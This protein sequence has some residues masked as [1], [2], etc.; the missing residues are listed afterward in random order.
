MKT[1]AAE[2]KEAVYFAERYRVVNTLGSGGM[3]TVYLAMDERLDRLIAVKVIHTHLHGN[4]SL[5]ERFKI[6]ARTVAA[7]HSPYIVEI[8]DYGTQDGNLFFI[9]EFIDGRTLNWILDRLNAEPMDPAVAAAILCQIAEGIAVAANSGI[10]HRDLKPDNILI[11][12]QGYLKV[13]DFGIAH[14]KDDARLTSTGQVLGTPKFMSPEQ[15]AGKK[16]VSLQSDMFSLGVIFYYC[17]TGHPPFQAESIPGIMMAITDTAHRPLR[18]VLP[19]IDPVLETLV[20]TLLQKDSKKRGSGATWLQQEL[21]QYLFGKAIVDPVKRIRD[22]ITELSERGIQTARE[23][24][25][26]EV[27]EAM[28]ALEQAKRT[29]V[30]LGRYSSIRGQVTRLLD[31]KSKW[32]WGIVL[33]LFVLAGVLASYVFSSLQAKSDRR[34]ASQVPGKTFPVLAKNRTPAVKVEQKT[35]A[36]P[37]VTVVPQTPPSFTPPL[38]EVPKPLVN[39]DRTNPPRIRER[40]RSQSEKE[41]VLD[42]SVPSAMAKV[43]ATSSPP[44]AEVFFG[45]VS[46]GFCPIQDLEVRPGRYRLRVVW[47][48][49]Q[50]RDTTIYI[51]AGNNTFLFKGEN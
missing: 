33:L 50:S 20:E 3:A 23:V 2:K 21:K 51:R 7:L 4:K 40:K 26:L 48:E 36:P 41:K 9:M 37:P 39:Q 1:K 27:E 13:T 49:T 17:L 29:K 18:S 22:Y 28:K 32:L 15:V 14:L 5:V 38:S 42:P 8:Y 10:V 46:W 16:E 12:C 35:V 47:R 11:S 34:I 6:E 45:D 19:G 43:S 44:F 24:D 25:W 31:K 30:G